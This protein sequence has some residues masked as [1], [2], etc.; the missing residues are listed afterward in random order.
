MFNIKQFIKHSIYF[1]PSF[2]FTVCHPYHFQQSTFNSIF[3]QTIPLS[4]SIHFIF[5]R[6]SKSTINFLTWVDFSMTS[7]GANTFVAFSFCW[8]Y[9]VLVLYQFCEPPRVVSFKMNSCIG[10][11]QVLFI[12]QPQL[13]LP[14]P[15]LSAMVAKWKITWPDQ[16]YDITSASVIKQIRAGH[17]A[18]YHMQ[19]YCCLLSW[20]CQKLALKCPNF[21][22]MTGKKLP[23]PYMQRF[24]AVFTILIWNDH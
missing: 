15:L 12:Y 7:W 24:V 17:Q 22:H 19:F 3:A 9:G 11:K 21:N 14:T 20:L 5:F 18:K 13:E 2:I 6:I 1:C 16:T 4:K 8:L 10:L 23:Q